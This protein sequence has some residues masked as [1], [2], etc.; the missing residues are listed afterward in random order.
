MLLF[1]FYF[2]ISQ[3]L[4]GLAYGL[5]HNHDFLVTL[6]TL[7]NLSLV[8]GIFLSYLSRP[9]LIFLAFYNDCPPFACYDSCLYSS[10]LI[11]PDTFF[12]VQINMI[13]KFVWVI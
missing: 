8:Q 7:S 5:F 6:C 3:L 2:M 10:S 9:A 4:L 13:Q 1:C 12:N 11:E